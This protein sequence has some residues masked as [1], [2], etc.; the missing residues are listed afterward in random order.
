[1][2]TATGKTFIKRYL[3]GQGGNMVGAL[4]VGIGGTA[5]TINDSRMQFEIARVSVDVINYDFS[6]DQLIFKG[7]LDET[8]EGKIYEVGIWTAENNM[9]LGAQQARLITSFDSVT[10]DW[11]N[12]TVDSTVTRIGVDSLKHAPAASGSSSSV[13]T[14]PNLDMSEYSS[15]DSFILA[16][17]VDNTNCASAK[18][19]LRT[20]S[21]NYYEY[22][23]TSPATGY[24]FA[25]IAKGSAVVT[26]TPNWEDINEV[27][28]VTTA[29]SSGSASVE[30]DGLRIEDF[31]ST[32]PEYGLI[33]RYIPAS[34]I[35]KVAGIVQDFEYALPVSIT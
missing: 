2:I 27:E 22:S 16:F 24:Q 18:F 15:V 26:G 33:A 25:T 28:I 7:T 5:A 14:I 34:P 3:A 12:E 29:K 31:D 10:E 6:T 11:T 35:T 19:R 4:S 32:D 1:M 9:A 17:N 21:S 13:L 20:D 23:V 8:V 30:Y